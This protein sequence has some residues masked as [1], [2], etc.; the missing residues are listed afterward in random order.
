M[1]HSGRDSRRKTS[2]NGGIAWA[3][4][5]TV[6]YLLGT[7]FYR[8]SFM[9]FGDPMAPAMVCV[10]GLTRNA[11]DFDILAQA[12]AGRF[13]VICT[14]LPGAGHAPVLMDKPSIDVIR[15]FLEQS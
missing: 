11:R 5:G 4:T 12:L 13:H 7:E 3:R 2:R 6:P 15:G 9:E 14:D 8:M 10:H 1:Q